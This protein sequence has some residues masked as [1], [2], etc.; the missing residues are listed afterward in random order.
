MIADIWFAVE[1]HSLMNLSLARVPEEI[2]DF[3][4]N[5]AKALL[6]KEVQKNGNV[7]A[8]LRFEDKNGIIGRSK[9]NNFGQ[10]SQ[11]SGVYRSRYSNK[12]L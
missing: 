4:F 12:Q 5:A 11:H 10:Q 8:S 6:D 3:G 7:P 9:V 1:Q 2:K